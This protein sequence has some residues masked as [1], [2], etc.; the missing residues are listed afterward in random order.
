MRLN[1]GL[2][3]LASH[4]EEALTGRGRPKKEN[5]SDSVWMLPFWPNPSHTL[6]M[7]PLAH[8]A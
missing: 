3:Q 6:A 1:K 4:D 2:K 7:P 5:Q 8:R